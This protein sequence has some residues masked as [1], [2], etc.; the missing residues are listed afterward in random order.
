MNKFYE[1]DDLRLNSESEEKFCEGVVSELEAYFDIE[2]ELKDAA[3]ARFSES[4]ANINEQI[5]DEE[6][7]TI[8]IDSLI[9]EAYRENEEL[10]N[11]K[12]DLRP[13][14]YDLINA[15]KIDL[16]NLVKKYVAG[17]FEEYVE[18][19]IREYMPEDIQKIAKKFIDE[20]FIDSI[21]SG[22]KL[23]A[24]NLK[25]YENDMADDG[26]TIEEKKEITETFK[27]DSEAYADTIKYLEESLQ[28]KNKLPEY[29]NNEY[30]NRA[31]YYADELREYPE[32]L[33]NY[34]IDDEKIVERAKNIPITE[35]DLYNYFRNSNSCSV[36]RDNDVNINQF[37]IFLTNYVDKKEIKDI[38]DEEHEKFCNFI[39][40][41]NLNYNNSYS[42]YEFYRFL[43]AD[44]ASKIN[45]DKN[46]KS[47]DTEEMGRSIK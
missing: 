8:A 33:T 46:K 28:G 4:V 7:K 12:W 13:Y 17:Y 30:L 10:I 19:Y 34:E 32:D 47:L 16:N 23:L 31:D 5:S 45:E 39:D 43:I 21:E 20:L 11:D 42:R 14:D 1:I 25:E 41:Y 3:K 6:L 29:I 40:K 15:V 18:K 24:D 38:S 9:S 22:K 44:L 35:E 36:L 27:F 26:K 37:I 2:K